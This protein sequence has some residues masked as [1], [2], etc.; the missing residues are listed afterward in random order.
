[1]LKR[2]PRTDVVT[3]SAAKVSPF[4]PSRHAASVHGTLACND[5]HSSIKDFPHPEKVANV[6][7]ATCHS[8]EASHLSGTIHGAL[9]D[10]AC[11]SCHGDA[12]EVTAAAQTQFTIM[13]RCSR[14]SRFC[15]GTSTW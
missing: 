2:T 15:C 1:M 6:Q 12:H 3:R 7:C 11:Q 13:R 10:V 5:C 4:D 8:D 14:P 9:G